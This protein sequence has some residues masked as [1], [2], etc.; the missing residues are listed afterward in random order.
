MEAVTKLKD[1]NTLY[2]GYRYVN[3]SIRY[4]QNMRVRLRH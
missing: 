3:Q 4:V 1:S 2:Y